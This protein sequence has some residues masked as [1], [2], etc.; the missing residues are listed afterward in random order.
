[1]T[2]RYLLAGTC[3]M[4]ALYCSGCVGMIARSV[5]TENISCEDA[6]SKAGSIADDKARVWVY[7]FGGGPT[8]WNTMGKLPNISFNKRVYSS[9]GNCF[10]Y[11][12]VPSGPCRVSTS[13]ITGK[14]WKPGLNARQIVL[15]GGRE[16]FI[17]ISSSANGP[18]L[19]GC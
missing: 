14:K 17:K 8:V 18:T 1:M 7:V 15:Q 9:A 3:L 11:A 6:T 10:F 13:I 2:S 5:A 19:A 4:I 16:Y 12:D